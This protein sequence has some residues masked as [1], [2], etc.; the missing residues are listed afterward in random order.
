M[1][2]R[3]VGPVE[4]IKGS[5]DYIS[6]PDYLS[7]WFEYTFVPGPDDAHVFFGADPCHTPA[8]ETPADRPDG[9]CPSCGASDALDDPTKPVHVGSL[10]TCVKCRRW[11]DQPKLDARKRY[12]QA[13]RGKIEPELRVCRDPEPTLAEL[14]SIEATRREWAARPPYCLR[15]RPDGTWYRAD[16]DTGQPIAD[17]S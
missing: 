12:E 16:A 8:R 15:R 6:D 17:V 7:P 1:R 14:R 5:P 13:R 11:G 3:T 2:R 10:T 9:T 4:V